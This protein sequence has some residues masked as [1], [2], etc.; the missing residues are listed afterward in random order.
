MFAFLFNALGNDFN[1][2]GSACRCCPDRVQAD[3]R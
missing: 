2:R 3:P 1:L